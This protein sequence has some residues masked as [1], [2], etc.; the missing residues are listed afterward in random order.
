MTSPNKTERLILVIEDDPGIGALLEDVLVDYGF[1]VT[2]AT[3]GDE[4]FR[5]L[6]TVRPTLI[7]LDLGLPGINGRRLLRMLR[8]DAATAAIAVIIVSAELA[9][10]PALRT[11][12]Q[13]VLPKPFT[14][15]QLLEAITGVLG[16]LSS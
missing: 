10:E 3:T 4:A 14:L 12:A 11:L 7:T 5:V 6:E 15:D 13:A 1:R 2:V 9:I 8:E 16:D